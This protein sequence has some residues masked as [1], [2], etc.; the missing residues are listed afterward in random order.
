MTIDKLLKEM[1]IPTNKKDEVIEKMNAAYKDGDAK[2]A[3]DIFVKAGGKNRTKAFKEPNIS[4]K[5]WN[6]M[7]KG[8]TQSPGKPRG[9]VK[10]KDIDDKDAYLEEIEKVLNTLKNKY[11]TELSI[12]KGNPL[13]MSTAS[14]IINHDRI[15]GVNDS[16]EHRKKKIEEYKKDLAK[17][18]Q[19]Y[20][21]KN[22]EFK[23]ISDSEFA[24]LSGPEK[25]KYMGLKKEAEELD[26]LK[27]MMITKYNKK[28]GEER[29]R[30]ARVPVDKALE[31]ME[32]ADAS[33]KKI[34]NIVRRYNVDKDGITV[35]ELKDFVNTVDKSEIPMT[36]DDPQSGEKDKVSREI[37]SAINKSKS[38]I[39]SGEIKN[40]DSILGSLSKVIKPKMKKF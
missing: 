36:G 10:S 33:I 34:S 12:L 39:S 3:W 16:A 1:A 28:K 11:E 9:V 30:K 8:V 18:Q 22:N 32:I 38:A 14:K 21:S 15:Y 19:I 20:N 26:N 4:D 7:Q 35:D 40:I 23:K 2:K 27:T 31:N 37:I 24:K 5:M 29:R 6:D 25:R 13:N 17:L